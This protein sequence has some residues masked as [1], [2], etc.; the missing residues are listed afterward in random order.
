M[1]KV[2][3]RARQLRYELQLKLARAI[4]ILEVA[5]AIGMDRERLNKIELGRIKGVSN[6][7]F[8]ALCEYY[9]AALGRLV[10]TN[11]ILGYDPNNRRVAVQEAMEFIPA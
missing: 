6:Q 9:S 4:P 5:T 8:I 11:E 1:P 7:E 3:P 2:V 10:D